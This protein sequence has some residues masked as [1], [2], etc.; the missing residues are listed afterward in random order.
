MTGAAFAAFVIGAALL[1]GVLSGI[2]PPAWG[3][4]AIV[5]LLGARI[6][7]RVRNDYHDRPT[8]APQGRAN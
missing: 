3:H 7:H 4:L 1:A 8:P 2:L 5:L 6:E